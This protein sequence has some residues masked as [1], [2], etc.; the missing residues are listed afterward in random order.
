MFAHNKKKE[1]FMCKKLSILLLIPILFFSTA[2]SGFALGVSAKSAILIEKESGD[3]IFEKNASSPLPLAST[4]KIMTA[5]VAIEAGGLDEIFKIPKEATG[6][7]G[8]SIYLKEGEELSRRQ[9]LY[10][11]LLESANDA[12]VALAYA[13]YGGIEPFVEKMNDKANALGL[14]NTHFTNPHGLPNKEHYS[15]CQDLSILTRYAL[16]NPV[17]SE[18]CATKTYKIPSI[19]GERLLVNHNKLL[20]TYSGANGVKTG[21]TKLSGRCLVS[22]AMR[23]GVWLIAVTLNAPDDW[24]DHSALFDYG[25]SLYEN[26]S[27]AS[28]GGY[29]IEIPI[30][31]E[32]SVLASNLNGF[33]TT[34]KK[35]SGDF[36]AKLVYKNDPKA[37]ISKGDAVGKI[38]FYNHGKE[39]GSVEL[40]S[41]ESIKTTN[42]ITNIFERLFKNGKNQTTKI[43]H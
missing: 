9:L 2:L 21:F 1:L 8:S 22:S 4:T 31:G 33:S 14:L 28:P 29:L 38:V 27:L 39:I 12:S 30:E 20:R 10:A 23:D 37:P 17:F 7:E 5:L 24:H 40:F 41:L 35:S 6:I 25:F 13:T 15:S 11:L 18:I 16:D 43:L 26:V 42:K 34:I 3:I 19:E 32:K 36:S